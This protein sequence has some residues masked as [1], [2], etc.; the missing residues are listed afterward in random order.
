MVGY[1]SI[2]FLKK[3]LVIGINDSHYP[4]AIFLALRE[5]RW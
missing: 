5:R 2:V 3:E 1:V 4:I